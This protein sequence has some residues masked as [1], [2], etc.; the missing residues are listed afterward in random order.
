MCCFNVKWY[1]VCCGACRMCLGAPKQHNFKLVR[2]VVHAAGGSHLKTD[3]SRKKCSGPRPQDHNSGANRVTAKVG[4]TQA[5]ATFS[6]MIVRPDRSTPYALA[7]P[8]PQ[9]VFH[10]LLQALFPPVPQVFTLLLFFS[11]A[12]GPGTL[13]L[14]AS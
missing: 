14:E 1:V 4:L 6:I 8:I 13:A 12:Q 10:L 11:H 7:S 2:P 5:E 9:F 3:V